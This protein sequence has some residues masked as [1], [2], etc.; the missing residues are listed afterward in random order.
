LLVASANFNGASM[1]AVLQRVES[2]EVV[3]ADEPVARTGKGI[4]VFLGI[5]KGDGESDADYLKEKIINLRIFEDAEGKM[6]L[7]LLDVA[8]DLLVVS[9]FTLLADCRK[10]RRPSFVNACEPDHARFLYN[11]F[12]A[13]AKTHVKNVAAGMFQELMKVHLV[14]DGPVTIIMESRKS[15][16]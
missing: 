4:L 2:A 3:V 10:G 14:N 8:G 13:A 12:I 16:E 1:K 7:S 15:G 9:Q 5:E 11:Y 6:N